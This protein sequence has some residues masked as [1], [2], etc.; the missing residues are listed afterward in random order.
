[1]VRIFLLLGRSIT[2]RKSWE[3]QAITITK[4]SRKLFSSSRNI[5]PILLSLIMSSCNYCRV[6]F[7]GLSLNT[8]KYNTWIKIVPINNLQIQPETNNVKKKTCSKYCTITFN[9]KKVANNERNLTTQ[10]GY[11]F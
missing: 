9:I 2:K 6:K 11:D 3:F 1:M 5:N 4:L 10:G 8:H 7:I